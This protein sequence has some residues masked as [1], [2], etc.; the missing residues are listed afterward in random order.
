MYKKSEKSHFF[1]LKYRI[2]SKF[3][4]MLRIKK[5]VELIVRVHVA[6]SAYRSELFAL[7]IFT[8][9]NLGE[10]SWASPPCF[11]LFVFFLLLTDAVVSVSH[12]RG[13]HLTAA[14]C[15]LV[16]AVTETQEKRYCIV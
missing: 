5:K 14:L 4:L 7:L 2:I 1:T 10:N 15:L 12:A 13:L 9:L 6:V 16:A 8:E 11:I 3:S